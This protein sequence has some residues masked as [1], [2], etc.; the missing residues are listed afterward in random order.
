LYGGW[1]P[2]EIICPKTFAFQNNTVFGDP[3]A[4]T[5]GDP[6]SSTDENRLLTKWPKFFPIREQSTRRCV[7]LLRLPKGKQSAN[8]RKTSKTQEERIDSVLPSL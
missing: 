2:V 1:E 6:D 3:L 4:V 7:S 5:I 8:P